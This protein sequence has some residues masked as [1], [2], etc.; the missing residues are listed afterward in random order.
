VKKRC[1]GAKKKVLL[2]EVL[3]ARLTHDLKR[4]RTG[5]FREVADVKTDL[6]VLIQDRES[7]L[8]ERAQEERIACCTCS[9]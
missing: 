8:E 9:S 4:Q 3:L 1:V 7:E 6:E 5:F 2:S